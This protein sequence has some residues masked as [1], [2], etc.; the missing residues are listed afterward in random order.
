MAKLAAKGRKLKLA[1]PVLPTDAPSPIS[2]NSRFDDLRT[3]KEQSPSSSSTPQAPEG[4][5]L[6][7]EG[8]RFRRRVNWRRREESL[9]MIA[10]SHRAR[11]SFNSLQLIQPPTS[12][13]PTG[14]EPHL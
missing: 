8:G 10:S 6:N 12:T 1:R 13:M 9:A 3:S 5:S 4:D 14:I 11:N 2:G 7:D